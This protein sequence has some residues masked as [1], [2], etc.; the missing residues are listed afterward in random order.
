MRLFSNRSQRTSKC[1]KNI[2]DT[3]GCAS[4]ATF[5]VLPHFDVICDLLLNRHTA[6]WNLFVR[7]NMREIRVRMLV[8][9]TSSIMIKPFAFSE[10]L[11]EGF[12]CDSNKITGF[13]PP[14]SPSWSSI[15]ICSICNRRFFDCFETFYLIGLNLIT[16]S[17]PF[18]HLSGSEFCPPHTSHF[19]SNKHIYPSTG[20]E[21]VL[22]RIGSEAFSRFIPLFQISIGFKTVKKAP[23]TNRTF[24][25]TRS[26]DSKKNVSWFTH[27]RK[28]SPWFSA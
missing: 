28:G 16:L 24:I 5:L 13:T 3:L 12:P 7:Y 1:G 21:N 22:Y 27:F 18:R 23:I 8:T 25:S 11:Y 20:R 9:C 14:N 2:S 6:T 4:C 15:Y 19:T 10:C 17:N 26:R